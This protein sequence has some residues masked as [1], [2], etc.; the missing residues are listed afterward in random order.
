[1]RPRPLKILKINSSKSL[2]V[3]NSSEAYRTRRAKKRLSTVVMPLLE[4][5]SRYT[6]LPSL[7]LLAG[8]A[9]KVAAEHRY[10]VYSVHCGKT[11]EAVPRDLAQFDP[12]GF[13]GTFLGHFAKFLKACPRE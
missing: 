2:H 7:T 5:L 1:M 8:Q 10:E 13:K 3:P 9:E 6:G 12:D 11:T 4:L